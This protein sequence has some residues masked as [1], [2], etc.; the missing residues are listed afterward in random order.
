MLETHSGYPFL[1]NE[2]RHHFEKIQ[3]EYL[4]MFGYG[5]IY[6]KDFH[7]FPYI[8]RFFDYDTFMRT[9]V[10]FGAHPIHTSFVAI[11]NFYERYEDQLRD[12]N[13]RLEINEI[14]QDEYDSQ[15]EKLEF[16]KLLIDAEINIE[17]K[18]KLKF[19]KKQL[20]KINEK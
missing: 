4:K 18:K 1:S 12:L 14:N 5:F 7:K 11:N 10:K 6:S 9:D 20:A 16:E 19:L 15:L 8:A 3:L 17:A 2:Q 13:V